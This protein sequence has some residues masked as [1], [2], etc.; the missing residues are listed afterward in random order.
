MYMVRFRNEYSKTEGD[1][2]FYNCAEVLLV[3]IE[4]T[5]DNNEL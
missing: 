1:V 2:H 4:V 3:I 5:F